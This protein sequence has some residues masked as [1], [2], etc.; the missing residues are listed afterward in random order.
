M[1]EILVDMLQRFNGIA[2][3]NI[4]LVIGGISAVTS[5]PNTSLGSLLIA[6]ISNDSFVISESY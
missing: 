4:V 1:V 5:S 6:G 3:G 2:G